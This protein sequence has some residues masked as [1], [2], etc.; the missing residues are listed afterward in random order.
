MKEENVCY[1]VE[2]CEILGGGVRILHTKLFE[3]VS[4][5]IEY[6]NKQEDGYFSWWQIVV[7]VQPF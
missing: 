2:Q 5:A 3:D 1:I 6:R 4:E 7:E